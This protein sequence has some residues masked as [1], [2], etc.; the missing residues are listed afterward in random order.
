VTAEPASP[1]FRDLEDERSGEIARGLAQTWRRIS[2]AARDA[3]RDPEDVTLVVVTKD[4]GAPDLQRLAALGVVDVGEARQQ[5]LRDK[6]AALGELAGSLRWHAI[7]RLQRNKA[8][9]V[10]RLADVVHSIDDI[11]LVP[12]VAAGALDADRETACLVQVSLDGAPDRGGVPAAEVDR[13]AAAVASQEGL[14]LRGVMAVAPLD[15]DPGAAFDR[16][17]EVADRVRGAHPGATWLSAGMSGDLE[18]AVVRGAT[19][20]RV[21]TAIL[22]SRPPA[23]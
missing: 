21:G 6:H 16:L 11:R 1:D 14:V 8:R 22:G 15:G 4:H 5:Q 23:R 3:G 12:L 19:H 13:L 18:A 20:V 7:G 10:G 17:A 2:A 9:S